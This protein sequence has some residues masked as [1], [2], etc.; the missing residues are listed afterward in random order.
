[1]S[2][3]HKKMKSIVTDIAKASYFKINKSGIYNNN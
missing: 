3:L 1:M 2:K